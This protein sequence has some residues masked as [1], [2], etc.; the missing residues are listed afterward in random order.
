M[1]SILL[2]AG[3][4]FVEIGPAVT[5]AGTVQESPTSLG[6]QIQLNYYN[7]SVVF[8]TRP[9]V[10]NGSIAEFPEFN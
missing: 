5:V 6:F 8:R 10:E 1:S 4:Y 2:S 7:N 9:S 3:S